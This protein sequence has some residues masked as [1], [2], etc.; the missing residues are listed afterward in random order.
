[1]A[2]MAGKP[3]I[4]ETIRSE[5]QR[6]DWTRYRLAKESGLSESVVGRFLSGRGISIPNL[7]RV[8]DALGL[9]IRRTK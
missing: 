8:L 9:E 2:R 6:R 5:M 7:E 1:M 4:R 3:D